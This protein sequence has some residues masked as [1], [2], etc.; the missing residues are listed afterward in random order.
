MGCKHLNQNLLMI[1]RN[2]FWVPLQIKPIQTTYLL[3]TNILTVNL[4]NHSD[5]TRRSRIA[6]FGL[7][8]FNVSI[9]SG[10]I[11]QHFTDEDQSS[12]RKMG[13]LTED[14][15]KKKTTLRRFCHFVWG[16][17][18]VCIP[19]SPKPGLLFILMLP[20]PLGS[21][22]RVPGASGATQNMACAQHGPLSAC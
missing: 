8:F 16:L 5:E 1:P 12:G 20:L 11:I 21:G 10:I 17:S 2:G 3:R 14:K 4:W 9:S 22:A 19:S 6:S 7:L 15:K 13:G 18:S